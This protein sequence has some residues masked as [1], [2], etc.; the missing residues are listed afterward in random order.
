VAAV[1]AIEKVFVDELQSLISPVAYEPRLEIDY[2]PDLELIRLFGYQPELRRSGATLKLD[3][4][5]QGLT[6]VVLLRFRLAGR[7]TISSR[8]PVK[9]RFT[10]YDL[11]QKRQIT[12]T[13]ESFLS[14]KPD[15][16]GDMLKDPEVG[17][18]YSIALLAQAIREMA[19]ACETHRF[20]EAE[21]L[22]TATIEKT[23]R[24]YPNLEDPDIRR[25]LLIARN[26]Q[27]NLR[28]YI[29]QRDVWSD[30]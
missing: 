15:G 28:K 12:K 29:Q 27:D 7:R 25:T 11:E 3:N 2:D 20:Q 22:I 16:V 19:E 26:Y 17:K 24:S 18:N 10:Y 30:R 6:Q 13:Q 1:Q 5:N 21:N 4:M 8:L 9:I 23:Y 14:V